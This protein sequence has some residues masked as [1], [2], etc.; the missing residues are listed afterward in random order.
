MAATQMVL[1]STRHRAVRRH[2]RLPECY[3]SQTGRCLYQNAP[4]Y[5]DVKVIPAG[6]GRVEGPDTLT[7]DLTMAGAH[8]D[9]VMAPMPSLSSRMLKSR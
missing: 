4:K 6:N 7:A 3:P 5:A 8:G 1:R 9:P 2:P